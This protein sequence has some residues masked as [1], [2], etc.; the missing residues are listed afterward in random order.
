MFLDLTH[1]KTELYKAT[2]SFVLECC[3]A[4]RLLPSDEKYILTQQIRR[5]ALSV[6]LNFS[7]GASRKSAAERKR[8]Y[9][10]SRSSLI[11]IDAALDVAFDLEYIK[12]EQLNI[13][14]DAMYECFRQL[15]AIINSLK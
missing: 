14:G 10:I 6:H 11:E 8:F 4:T 7:E 13:L 3:K 2:R 1:T 9:E 15:S 12:K 5:A